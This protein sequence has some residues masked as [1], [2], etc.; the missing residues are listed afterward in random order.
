MGDGSLRSSNGLQ[1]AVQMCHSELV[2][3]G[4]F[5][6]KRLKTPT[7]RNCTTYANIKLTQHTPDLCAGTPLD[8]LEG[9]HQAQ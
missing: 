1:V 8:L 9:C 5:T 4:V 6:L 7:L 2:S 3:T